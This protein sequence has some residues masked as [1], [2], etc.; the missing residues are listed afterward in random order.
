MGFAL[1]KLK[2]EK[3]AIRQRGG[4]MTKGQL[5]KK[6]AHLESINDQLVTEVTYVDHLMRLVGFS[7]GLVGVKATAEEIVE[8]GYPEINEK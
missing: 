3:A 6:I 5:L 4:N 2:D 8:K 1:Y 7:E